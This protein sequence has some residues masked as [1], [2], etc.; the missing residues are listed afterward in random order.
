MG[1]VKVISNVIIRHRFLFLFT[2][3]TNYVPLLYRG[4]WVTLLELKLQRCFRD[5]VFKH[6]NRTPT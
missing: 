4:E 1:S 6:Y 3:D 5:A 2:F